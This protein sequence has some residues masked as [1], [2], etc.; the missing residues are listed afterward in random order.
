MAAAPPGMLVAHRFLLLFPELL[1]PPAGLLLGGL[2]L[3]V[4]DHV[5]EPLLVRVHFHVR[6]DLLTSNNSKEPFGIF[7]P[8]R[9][10]FSKRSD[11]EGVRRA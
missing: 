9:M 8:A 2:S 7:A 11:G 1:G 4:L 3:A 10:P 5:V 6:L